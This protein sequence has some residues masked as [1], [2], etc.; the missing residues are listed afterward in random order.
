MGK[1]RSGCLDE[2]T[3]DKTFAE[4]KAIQDKKLKIIRKAKKG[5][6]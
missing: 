2:V 4:A 6:K 5:K 3:A 1:F